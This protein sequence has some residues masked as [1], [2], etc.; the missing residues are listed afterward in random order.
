M[1]IRL[2]AFSTS[3][4]EAAIRPRIT[5]SKLKDFTIRTP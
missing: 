3:R 4:M 5:S 2:A 1:A